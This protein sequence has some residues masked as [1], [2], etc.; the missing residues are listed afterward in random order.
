MAEFQSTTDFQLSSV[1]I[2]PSDGS[3]GYQIK[4]LVQVFSYIESVDYP[5]VMGSM[6]V[7]DSGGLLNRLPIQGGEIVRI[8]VKTNI[9]PDG[10]RIYD[11]CLENC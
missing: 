1:I 2:S 9:D 7:V 11:A 8:K 10:F 6:I 5:C 4:Q 3:N